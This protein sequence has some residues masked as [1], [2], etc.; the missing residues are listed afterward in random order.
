[1]LITVAS[2]YGEAL[3]AGLEHARLHGDHDRGRL[4]RRGAP[5][6]TT[7]QRQPVS[8]SCIKFVCIGFFC[9]G[10]VCTYRICLH[11]I[12]IYSIC[13]YRTFQYTIC[14]YRI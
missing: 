2:R 9:I 7:S 12:S 10:F 4:A 6:A 3:Q 13:L 14:L 5:P 8:S 1:M 11:T